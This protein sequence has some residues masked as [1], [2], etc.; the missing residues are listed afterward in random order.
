MRV[1][2]D[3]ELA[4][5]TE[6]L[7]R[8]RTSCDRLGQYGDAAPLLASLRPPGAIFALLLIQSSNGMGK[9]KRGLAEE[10]GRSK[11]CPL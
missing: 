5:E 9:P 11:P 6:V 8:T 4:T 10:E 7:K 3:K 1:L 2:N